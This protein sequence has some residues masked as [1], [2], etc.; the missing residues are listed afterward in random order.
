MKYTFW[1]LLCFAL[2][3]WA[4]EPSSIT[5]LSIGEVLR[6]D[7]KA[8][9]ETRILNVYLP[10]GYR[11]SIDKSYPVIYILDGSMDEDFLHLAGLVQFG[12]FPWIN[13]VPQSI[14]VGIANVD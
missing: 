5:P 3:A 13:M 4:Q 10:Q 6:F 8:L 14:V 11:D 12:S 7:S 9:D 2:P 1:I